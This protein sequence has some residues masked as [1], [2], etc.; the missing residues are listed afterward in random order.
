MGGM[1]V[2]RKPA[3]A[4]QERD[5]K[6]NNKNEERNLGSVEAKRIHSI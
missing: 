1:L 2:W 4:G 5:L 3:G 6:L